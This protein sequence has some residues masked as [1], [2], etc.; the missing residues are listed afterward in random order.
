MNGQKIRNAILVFCVN[1]ITQKHLKRKHLADP[2]TINNQIS[3]VS[4]SKSLGQWRTLLKYSDALP[5]S[6]SF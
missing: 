1:W 5:S 3:E 4:S 6:I 2:Y